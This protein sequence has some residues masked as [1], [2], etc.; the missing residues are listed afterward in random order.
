MTERTKISLPQLF[1]MKRR[2]EKITMITAY[3][4]WQGRLADEAGIEIVLVG[5]SMAMTELGYPTTLPISMDVMVEHARA[6][7]RGCQYAFVLG[8]MPYM[9]YQPSVETAIRNAGRFM[10]ESACAGVKL[11]GGITMVDRV[12]G[13]VKAGIPVMGHLGLTPQSMSMLGGF[14][15]QGKDALMAKRIVD[16]AK[17]LEDAGA[18][19]VLL[20]CVPAQ[21]SRLIAE[22]AK[23]PIISIGA[24][25][26]CDGQLL[27][28]HDLFG[29]YAAFTPKF[30]KQYANV[31]AVISE[32]LNRYVE[33]IR[34]GKFPEPKHTFTIAEEQFEELKRM[35]D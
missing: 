16:D 14:K 35:L 4:V 34:T 13:L 1:D 10:S 19:A 25:P 31:A 3:N 24:G 32:G 28:F 20:E 29:L 27:I 6:V 9:T 22:R 15:V 12:E 23:I 17:A 26:Y 5:D 7:T 21:V 2:G 33:E 8:D 18:F 11:E 30:S